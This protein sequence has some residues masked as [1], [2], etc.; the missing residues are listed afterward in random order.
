MCKGGL[1][2]TGNLNSVTADEEARKLVQQAKAYTDKNMPCVGSEAA[3]GDQLSQ[4]VGMSDEPLSQNRINQILLGRQRIYVYA[5][6]KWETSTGKGDT[7]Q[8]CLWLTNPR[9]A[10]D[11]LNKIKWQTCRF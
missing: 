7:S 3:P 9:E 5:W 6:A 11:D 2:V 1:L 8:R 10:Q 4:L